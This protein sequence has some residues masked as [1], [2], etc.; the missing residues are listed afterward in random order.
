MN[1]NQNNVNKPERPTVRVQSG[2]ASADIPKGTPVCLKIS[3]TDDGLLVILPSGSA[4]KAHA[5]AYGVVTD[6]L[7]PAEL[8]D[9]QVFG[10]CQYALL[11][12]QTRAASSDAF[13]SNSD[14]FGTGVILNIDTINNAFSTSGGTQAASGFLPFAVLAE[15]VASWASSAS[16]TSDTRTAIT[17]AT[18]VFLRM[19]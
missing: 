13:S 6:T 10:F 18:K 19:M 12:R 16:A 3:G 7:S 11:R 15:S 17:V 2:E 4:A 1:I 5:F 14:G 9:A 8:G